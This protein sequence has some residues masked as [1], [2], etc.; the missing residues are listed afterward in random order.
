MKQLLAFALCLLIAT[1]VTGQKKDTKIM[2]KHPA[3]AAGRAPKNALGGF[4]LDGHKQ[5]VQGVEFFIYQAD[6]TIA[7]SGFTDATGNYTT[8]SV[9]PGKYRVKI[10]YPSARVI[11]VN[12]IT[13]KS[14]ITPLNV[15]IAEP[16]ADTTLPYTYFVPVVEKKGAASK[17]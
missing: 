16:P 1:S 7:A 17:K 11:M 2:P 3:K 14:G 5:P 15:T 8:N 6:S 4:V 13:M 9:M 10:V 12:N